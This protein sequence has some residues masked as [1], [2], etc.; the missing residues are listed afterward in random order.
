MM[1]IEERI[2]NRKMKDLYE[3]IRRQDTVS[4]QELLERSGL[5]GGTLTRLLEEMAGQGLIVEV[6]FGESTGGRRPILYR[7]NPGYGYV[8]GL[9]ISRIH[10]RLILFDMQ[11]EKKDHKTWLMGENMTPGVFVEE[12]SAEMERMLQR[13]GLPVT[14][15]LGM[16]IGA[17]GPLDREAGVIVDPLYFP[18]KGWRDVPI[19]AMFEQRFRFPVQLDNGANTAI[20]GEYWAD[21]PHEYKHLLYVHGG[22]GLRSAMM[23]GGKVVYGAVDMEGAVG[24]MIIQADGVAPRQE[25]GNFGALE[26]YA[27]IYAIEQHVQAILKTGRPSLILELAGHPERAV[28]GHVVEAA[29]LQDRLAVEVLT[30]AAVFFGI[31]LANLLNVLH[32][33]K[34]IL[35][36]PLITS[37]DLVFQTATQV[38]IRKTYYFPQYQVVFSRGKLGDDALAAGAGVMMLNRLTE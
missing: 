18:A 14:L 13:H 20:L 32:P 5:K 26:S 16:G 11:L 6:G 33:E 34:V 4:K 9:E 29:R 31:G 22:V 10:T 28:F 1:P 37:H 15:V 19:C 2:T 12:V 7:T 17:V 3:L 38:A 36:G 21:R 23:T 30:Q 35:G 25:E 27:S 24:Q 8:F